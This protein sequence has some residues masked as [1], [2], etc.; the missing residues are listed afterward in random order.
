[1]VSVLNFFCSSQLP[2][3]IKKNYI[4]FQSAHTGTVATEVF[5]K[6]IKK[7]RMSLYNQFRSV[8][9]LF[10]ISQVGCQPSVNHDLPTGLES[11]PPGFSLVTP[12]DPSTTPNE[13]PYVEVIPATLEIKRGSYFSYVLPDGWI[14]GED[15]QFAL[16]MVASDQ[17]A[18]S[19][20]VGNS[21]LMPDYQ[22][23]RFV[24]DK[25]SALQPNYIQI[26]NAIQ[27]T[28][29]P[30]FQ[31]AYVYDVQLTFRGE[32]FAGSVTCNIAPYYGGSTMAMTAAM[33]RADQWSGYSTWLPSVSR[34]ISAIDGAAFGMRGLMQQNIELSTAYARAAQDYRE[35][36][37]K[38]QA[39][40]TAERNRSVDSRNTEFRETIGA[41]HTWS[42]PYD[43]QRPIEL[44]TKY[45]HY[46]IDQQGRILG[47]NDSGIDPNVGSTLEWRRLERRQ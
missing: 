17:S 14:L 32:P 33:S 6:S 10:V 40:M 12:A 38:N 44:S 45:E 16:S 18:I 9:V 47:S 29:A 21:G 27:T 30:G 46:W 8:M 19:L 13:E 23:D 2:L 43:L 25:L 4:G 5:N 26:T 39:S 22:P 42:N 28:P 41:V 15:G 37:Q 34:Q 7:S 1:L 24:Y 20:M 36:S 3:Y 31:Y 11:I 35:W